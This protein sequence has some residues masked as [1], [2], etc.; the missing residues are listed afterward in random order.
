LCAFSP[1][2]GKAVGKGY[3]TKPADVVREFWENYVLPYW[4]KGRIHLIMDNLSAHKKALR[5]LP[6]RFRRRVTVYWTP[7]NSSWLNL[8]DSY[9]ATLKQ[10]ALQNTNYTT[11][12][13]IEHG[14]LRGVEYLNRNPR[15]YIWKKL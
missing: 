15:P 9:F 14:L 13:E 6:S 3:R 5:E 10:I 11:P 1:Q 12:E 8:A 2:T 4:P 7:V